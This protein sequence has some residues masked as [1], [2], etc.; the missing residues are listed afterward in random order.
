MKRYFISQD[1]TLLIVYNDDSQIEVFEHLAGL[2][3]RHRIDIYKADIANF[4][5]DHRLS[6][7]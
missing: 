4:A 1:R 5:Y 7:Q 3:M 2:L 6:N